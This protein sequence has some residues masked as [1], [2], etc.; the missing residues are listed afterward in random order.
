MA[1]PNMAAVGEFAVQL[2]HTFVAFQ[3]LIM[4]MDDAYNNR[5]KIGFFGRDKGLKSHIKYEAKLKESLIAMTMDGI[6]NRFD[7]A[8]EFRVVLL[9]VFDCWFNM[10]P[11]WLGARLLV[12]EQFASDPEQGRMLI[13]SLMGLSK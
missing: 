9:T 3:N 11:G 13:T 7:T 1:L 4:A 5:G 2:P 6:V 8:E 10:F 12:S